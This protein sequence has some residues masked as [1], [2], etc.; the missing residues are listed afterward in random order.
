MQGEEGEAHLVTVAALQHT[1][2]SWKTVKEK[3]N[4]IVFKKI[5]L[6]EFII[7]IIII[8]I[9]IIT[10]LVLI[11]FF[12]SSVELLICYL[13]FDSVSDCREATAGRF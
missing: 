6:C 11:F 1:H 9:V 3:K 2:A 8:P 10:T 7:I 5:Y 12:C 4:C 13:L